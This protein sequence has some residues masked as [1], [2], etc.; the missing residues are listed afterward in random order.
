MLG[1][2]SRRDRRPSAA[3][4]TF[5]PVLPRVRRRNVKSKS[6]TKAPCRPLHDFARPGSLVGRARPAAVAVD[7]PQSRAGMAGPRFRLVHAPG[8]LPCSTR[9]DHTNRTTWRRGKLTAARPLRARG[10]REPPRAGS[11]CRRAYRTNARQL[12]LWHHVILAR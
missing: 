5:L 8:D 2:A 9:V 4:L 3:D 12:L 7:L 1:G 6:R 11:V 10:L